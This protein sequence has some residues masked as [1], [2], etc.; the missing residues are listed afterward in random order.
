MITFIALNS[1]LTSLIEGL[2]SSNPCGFEF[3]ML[4]SHLLLSFFGINNMSKK[5]SCLSNIS[6]HLPAYVCTSA[7]CTH[8]RIHTC[9]DFIHLYS[10]SPPDVSSRPLGSHL[11]ASRALFCIYTHIHSHTLPPSW[12]SRA[13]IRVSRSISGCLFCNA[14]TRTSSAKGICLRRSYL[15]LTL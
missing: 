11:S 10:W 9:R 13:S 12:K 4:R 1:S 3:S 15:R 6:S 5:K 14:F 8:T 7:L 2:W